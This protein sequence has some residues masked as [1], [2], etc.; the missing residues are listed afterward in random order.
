MPV[1]LLVECFLPRDHDDDLSDDLDLD[2]FCARW[3]SSADPD[4]FE[5]RVGYVSRHLWDRS[6]SV[7]WGK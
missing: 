7:G 1:F 6:M 3:R 5:S 4:P 2:R